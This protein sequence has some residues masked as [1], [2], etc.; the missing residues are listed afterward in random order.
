VEMH[1]PDEASRKLY[2][3]DLSESTEYAGRAVVAL[4]CDSNVLVKSGSLLF[5]ADLA[6]EYGFTDIDGKRVGNFYK[7]ALGR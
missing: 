2:R 6:E 5:V 4:A 7:L 3:Y 1:L